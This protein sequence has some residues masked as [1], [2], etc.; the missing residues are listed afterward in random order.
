MNIAIQPLDYALVAALVLSA[1]ATV[2]TARVLRS[3]IAL[4]LTSAVLAVLMYRL[5]SPLAAV[6]ELSVCAGLIPAIFISALG[7]TRRLSG[8]DLEERRRQ[9]W[10]G[11]AP[12]LI[13]VMLAAGGLLLWHLPMSFAMPPAGSPDVRAILWNQRHADLLGQVTVLLAGAFA[14]VILVKELRNGND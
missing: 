4:A 14:V 8:E 13:L 12:L 5:V 6:F 1:L 3:A 9:S 2:L 10:R 11:F 7:M